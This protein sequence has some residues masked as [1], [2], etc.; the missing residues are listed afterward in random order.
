MGLD[1]ANSTPS[2]KS[3]SSGLGITGSTKSPLSSKFPSS[4]SGITG[5]TQSPLSTKGPSMGLD[6]ANSTPFMKSLSSGLGITGSTESPLSSKF[7]SS[8]SGITGS[9][10]PLLSAKGPSSKLGISSGNDSPLFGEQSGLGRN[11]SSNLF[12][13]PGLAAKS[14]TSSSGTGVFSF[15]SQS[16]FGAKGSKP[17]LRDALLAYWKETN[18]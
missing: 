6:N 13:A 14:E 12:P 8:A 15:P 10:Q 1:N 9:T 18:P 11:V 4:A 2:M 5:S 17:S 16:S 7:P 3:L